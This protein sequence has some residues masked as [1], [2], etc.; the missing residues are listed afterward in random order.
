MKKI[1]FVG[2]LALGASFESNAQES[3]ITIANPTPYTI[4]VEF[5]GNPAALCTTTSTSASYSTTFGP[6]RVAS[7]LTWAAGPSA[8]YF[9]GIRL[10]YFLS[11][12]PVSTVD[13]FPCGMPDGIYPLTFPGGPTINLSYNDHPSISRYAF[14]IN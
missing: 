7:S 4:N 12:A 2:L 1:L 13:F 11:G 5:Y 14:T 3:S 6:P 10:T 9:T 8:N